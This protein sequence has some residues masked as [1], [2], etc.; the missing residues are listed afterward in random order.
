VGDTLELL[1]A[2][3]GLFHGVVAAM[4]EIV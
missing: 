4:V 2:Q 3:Q 1:A